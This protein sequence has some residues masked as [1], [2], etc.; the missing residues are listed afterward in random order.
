MKKNILIS[1]LIFFVGVI[2]PSNTI[3]QEKIS[4]AVAAN[5]ISAFKEI[6]AE[7]ETKTNIKVEATFASTGSLY[8]QIN[9]GAP[10]DLFLAADEKRP[11]ILKRDGWTDETFIYA[12]GQAILWTANKEICKAETW[13]EAL[14]N[15]EIKK[16]AI[17]NTVTAPYGTAAMIALQKVGQ[18]DALQ[19]KLVI[20]Q[21]IAQSFQYAETESVDAGFCALSAVSTPQGQ[22][23][24]FFHISEA[25]DIIQAACVAKKAKN[26]K[27][28][29]LFA[30]FLTSKYA[31]QIKEKYGYR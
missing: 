3:A 25:P 13:L 11:D 24:C 30:A 9:N 12:R 23:G 28:A 17:A 5:F 8:S 21:T 27:S 2:S 14:R 4:V 29:E 7:F 18:W 10:Y 31:T 15:G 26:R 1:M 6:A 19:N 20:A 22:K 16:I